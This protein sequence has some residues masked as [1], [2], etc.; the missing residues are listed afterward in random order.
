M[1]YTEA[2]ARATK[3]YLST[4][5]E[6]KVWTLPAIKERIQQAAADAGQSVNNYILEAVES[7]IKADQD[8]QEIPPEL[9]SRLIQWL[10]NKGLSDTDIVN[11]IEY[12]NT[13]EESQ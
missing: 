12:I 3:K 4:K 10:K 8:G 2:R 7:Q 1:T 5:A 11:C 13:P 9:I 6:I